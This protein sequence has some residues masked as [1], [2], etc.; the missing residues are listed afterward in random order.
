ME[1]SFNKP[2]LTGHEA[3]ALEQCLANN[4]FQGDKSFSNLCQKVL[5]T[6]F[7]FQHSLLTNSCTAA[8]EMSCLLAGLEPDDEVIL[9]SYTFVSTANAVV[10]RGATPVFVD[11]RKDT[12]NIDETLIESAITS[13]TKAII[14]VHYGGVGCEVD[15]LQE[16]AS[17]YGLILIEDAAQCI[18]AKYKNKY[19]GTFGDFG[20]LSF[21]ETKNIH[22]GE[23][24][25]LL[26]KDGAYFD[27]A[28]IIWQKGTDRKQFQ[29]GKV[30]K[31]SWR[32]IG[33][34][35][36]PNEMTA[37]FLHAQL[38]QHETIT[39]TRLKRW[40]YY[41]KLISQFGIDK[42]LKTPNPPEHC[43]H[44][45]HTF[46]LIF[47]DKKTRDTFMLFM[48]ENAVEV[49]THYEPLHSSEY[50]SRV[51]KCGSALT[52]SSWVSDSLCR[53]PLHNYLSEKQQDYVCSL[54]SKFCCEQS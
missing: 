50:G 9:P 23:G 37:A 39:Q 18:G 6:E 2:V 45:G 13:R 34:S 26:I 11:I 14:C 44:N 33:S 32:S 42:Y 28:Q 51:G 15:K 41:Q 46:Y 35:F 36:Y 31:Y 54:I 53:L 10:L 47:P 48:R 20:T 21:H 49:A 5:F 7:G 29:L 38:M 52:N 24:G 8:L 43:K 3:H 27:Q 19:L 22:S 12:L 40:N 4:E 30:S 1:V 25:A 16:L 17:K